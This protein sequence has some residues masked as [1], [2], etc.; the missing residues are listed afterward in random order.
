MHY[1]TRVIVPDTSACDLRLVKYFVWLLW[2]ILPVTGT[3]E[4]DLHWFNGKSFLHLSLLVVSWY[5]DLALFST[6][7]LVPAILVS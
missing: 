2:L 4:V 5:L 1:I 6:L 3:A 7:E